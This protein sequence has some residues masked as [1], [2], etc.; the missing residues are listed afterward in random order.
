[1]K[2]AWHASC[3]IW[4]MDEKMTMKATIK[5]ILTHGVLA[6]SALSLSF[7]APTVPDYGSGIHKISVNT[8]PQ[9]I[10]NDYNAQKCIDL[11]G[12]IEADGTCSTTYTSAGFTDACQNP[13]TQE[14]SMA[15]NEQQGVEKNGGQFWGALLAVLG[16]E[17]LNVVQDLKNENLHGQWLKTYAKKVLKVKSPNNTTIDIES[18]LN[19]GALKKHRLF[20]RKFTGLQKGVSTLQFELEAIGESIATVNNRAYGKNLLMCLNA[21]YLHDNSRDNSTTDTTIALQMKSKFNS[22]EAPSLI[23]KS[24][25]YNKC[26]LASQEQSYVALQ[27]GTVDQYQIFPFSPED[28]GFSKANGS[29]N[30]YSV[31]VD[32]EEKKLRYYA[33]NNQLELG[34][35]GNNVASAI[36]TDNEYGTTATNNQILSN[37][38]EGSS[39]SETNYDSF[40]NR[41][42]F[43]KHFLH[44]VSGSDNQQRKFCNANSTQV[45]C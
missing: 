16:K 5:T 34:M 26:N 22:H 9:E 41:Q 12:V 39:T 29:D 14:E 19:P 1:M 33:A 15:C 4:G 28:M 37:D 20:F 45:G 11:G 42:E 3:Y 13:T 25:F 36:F 27:L 40:N 8:S 35:A 6:I 7:C 2:S 21:S 17:V 32:G 30:K 18:S 23:N 44:L 43:Q 31:Y 24:A 10:F 38:A